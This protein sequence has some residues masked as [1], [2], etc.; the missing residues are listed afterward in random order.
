MPHQHY[1]AHAHIDYVSVTI[2]TPVS[3]Q[4]LGVEDWFA[5]AYYA[6]EDWAGSVELPFA[7]AQH[8]ASITTGAHGFKYRCTWADAG[9]FVQWGASHGRVHIVLSGAGCAV[10]KQV[11]KADL[12]GKIM[13]SLFDVSRVNFTRLDV[14]VDVMTD[15]SPDDAARYITTRKGTPS[16]YIESNSGKTIAFGGRS[17]ERYLRIYKYNP[18]HPRAHLLRWEWEMKGN[19][20]R[21]SAEAINNGENLHSIVKGLMK[22]YSVTYPPLL[23]LI[24]DSPPTLLRY[25]RREDATHTLWLYKVCIPALR[26]A[27]RTGT[28]SEQDIKK[29]LQLK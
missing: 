20:A 3:W 22:P 12:G 9:C 14:A 25:E 10:L 2:P 26:D 17:S 11:L 24:G 4:G 15:D 27:I 29:L 7:I 19:H 8:T 6:L 23:G 13:R 1:D 21:M 5:H 28:L 18:P 16:S